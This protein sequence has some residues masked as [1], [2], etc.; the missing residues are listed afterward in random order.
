MQLADRNFRVKS[1]VFQAFFKGDF[2]PPYKY[3]PEQIDCNF[4]VKE[5]SIHAHGATPKLQMADVQPSS[6]LAPP[7]KFRSRCPNPAP[8][9]NERFREAGG[10]PV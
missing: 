9:K 3:F 7:T 1:G 10:A 8:Q 4:Y 6:A 5:T 2:I